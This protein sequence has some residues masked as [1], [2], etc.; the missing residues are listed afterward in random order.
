MKFDQ[1]KRDWVNNDV[2]DGIGKSYFPMRLQYED[3]ASEEL[4]DNSDEIRDHVSF[5]VLET[6]VRIKKVRKGLE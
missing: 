2:D 5:R 3:R 4:V 1:T 6:R